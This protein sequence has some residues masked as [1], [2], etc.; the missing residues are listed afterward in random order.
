[1]IEK[2]LPANEGRTPGHAGANRLQQHKL[3]RLDHASLNSAIKRKRHACCGRIPVLAYSLHHS[4]LRNAELLSHHAH[5]AEVGLM[6]NKERHIFSVH[7]GKVRH[8]TGG[9]DEPFDSEL[10]NLTA[11]MASG[12]VTLPSGFW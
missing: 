12:T 4:L 8:F 3:A 2:A 1:M 9:I 6:R 7:A 5:D 10:E 11:K